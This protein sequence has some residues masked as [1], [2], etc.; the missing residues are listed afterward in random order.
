M[1]RGEVPLSPAAFEPGA[2]RC[3]DLVVDHLSKGSVL[4]GVVG[5]GLVDRPPTPVGGVGCGAGF[6]DGHESPVVGVAAAFQ[7]HGALRSGPAATIEANNSSRVIPTPRLF[8]IGALSA[9]I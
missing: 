4:V 9:A 6:H 3:G 8:R 2:F 7:V 1:R 5:L